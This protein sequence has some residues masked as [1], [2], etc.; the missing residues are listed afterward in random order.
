[1]N[2]IYEDKGG[3]VL[4]LVRVEF[5]FDF[6]IYELYGVGE[7]IWF[8]NFSFYGESNYDDKYYFL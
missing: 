6:C 2:K 1:M 4:E 5:N 3:N 7:V 8:L